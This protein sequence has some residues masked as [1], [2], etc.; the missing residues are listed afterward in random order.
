LK[1][2]VTKDELQN[3]ATYD[4]KTYPQNRDQQ[5]LVVKTS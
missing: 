1:A 5:R 4:A 2:D 3:Q